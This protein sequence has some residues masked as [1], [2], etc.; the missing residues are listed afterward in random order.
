MDRGINRS[1][2]LLRKERNE[3]QF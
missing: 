2:F 1:K 3:L